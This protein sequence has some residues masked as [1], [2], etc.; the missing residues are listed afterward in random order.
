MHH[1]S[2]NAMTLAMLTLLSALSVG[3]ASWNPDKTAEVEQQAR[4]AVA[5]FKKHD[6]SL[7]TYFDKA[8]AYAIYPSVGKG[9]IGIGGAYGSGSVYHK[10]KM[11]GLT[12]MTQVTI[13]WQLGGESYREIIF[14]ENQKA[15]DTFKKGDL[16][17]SAQAS[18]VAATR[19][20]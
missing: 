14:F 2:T 5:E 6:P 16:K 11:I 20:K 10:G 15:F 19:V 17:F 13:G 12:S 4:E 18:A 7:K 1:Y 9:G 3:C 8:Y